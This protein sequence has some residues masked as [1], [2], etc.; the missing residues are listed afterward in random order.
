MKHTIRLNERELKHLIKESVKRVLREEYDEDYDYEGELHTDDG[1]DAYLVC[2]DS[3]ELLNV[4]AWNT[5]K[6]I[7]PFW[8]RTTPEDFIDDATFV[9]VA[10]NG[11]KYKMNWVTGK[12]VEI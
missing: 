10:E 11:K 8:F 2:R 1:D 5:G 12:Y 7:F 3:D 6:L 9:A 4:E